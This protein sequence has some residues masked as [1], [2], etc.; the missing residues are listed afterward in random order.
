M[1]KPKLEPWEG[2]VW[3]PKLQ[4]FEFCPDGNVRVF[5]FCG[6]TLKPYFTPRGY[7]TPIPAFLEERRDR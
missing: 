1:N 4:F 3:D 7:Q 2:L 5:T 6:T